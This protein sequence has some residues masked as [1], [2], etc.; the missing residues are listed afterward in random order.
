MFENKSS[1]LTYWGGSDRFI[2]RIESYVYCF[3]AQGSFINITGGKTLESLS[4]SLFCLKGIL[5]NENK[6]MF[7][8]TKQKIDAISAVTKMPTNMF[9]VLNSEDAARKMFQFKSYHRVPG[10]LNLRLLLPISSSP[11]LSANVF[12]S[13]STCFFGARSTKDLSVFLQKMLS[14]L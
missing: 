12:V 14:I 3:M 4:E 10:K 13:G 2:V 6:E 11:N 7:D 5:Y 9:S 1:I 8:F